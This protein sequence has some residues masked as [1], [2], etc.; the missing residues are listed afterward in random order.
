LNF[1]PLTPKVDRFIPLHCGLSV[2]SA[3][4]SSFVL[5]YRVHEIGKGT[6]GKGRKGGEGRGGKGKG[7]EGRPP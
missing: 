7:R 4:Y 6:E 1:D 3:N 5:K 2:F